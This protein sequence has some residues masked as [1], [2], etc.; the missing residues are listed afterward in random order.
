[1]SCE[2]ETCLAGR[3][4]NLPQWQNVA[5]AATKD[6]QDSLLQWLSVFERSIDLE[7]FDARRGGDMRDAKTR[8]DAVISHLS[9]AQADQYSLNDKHRKAVQALIDQICGDDDATGPGSG[10][11]LIGF[12][13]LARG[14]NS[15]RESAN[16]A[17][18]IRQVAWFIPADTRHRYATVAA[19]VRVTG[20]NCT[21]ALARSTLHDG[22][23]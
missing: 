19:I 15:S 18:L 12:P 14:R 13:S 20:I 11:E 23:T 2:P 6:K 3:V 8:R 1:M 16:R 7:Q 22:K 17:W 10:M 4:R 21:S 9:D 5:N